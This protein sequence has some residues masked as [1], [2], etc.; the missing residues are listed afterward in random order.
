MIKKVTSIYDSA[1]E[2]YINPVMVATEQEA[3]RCFTETV[4]RGG[5]Q[6]SESSEYFT[7]FLL[8]EFDDSKGIIK[9]YDAPKKLVSAHEV[10]KCS[11]ISDENSHQIWKT[12]D[13][14]SE[15]INKIKEKMQ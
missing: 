3:I 13:K 8:G 7:L 5:T 15:E 11:N 14:I 12:I 10:K 6:L 2:V 9:M 1:T 4:N